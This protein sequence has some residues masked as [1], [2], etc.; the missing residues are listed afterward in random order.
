MKRIITMLASSLLLTATLSA[1]DIIHQVASLGSVSHFGFSHD[2]R[3]VGSCH[4]WYRD[5]LVWETATG[6]IV[7]R[8]PDVYPIMLSPEAVGLSHDGSFMAVLGRSRSPSGMQLFYGVN[9]EEEIKDAYVDILSKVGNLQQSPTYYL[10]IYDCDRNDIV[11]NLPTTGCFAWNTTNNSLVNESAP[12]R[13]S[14]IDF[15]AGTSRSVLGAERYAHDAFAFSP[16]G[17]VLA[18]SSRGQMTFWNAEDGRPLHRT[19]YKHRGKTKAIFFG[20]DYFLSGGDDETVKLWALPGFELLHSFDVENNDFAALA[21]SPDGSH[22]AAVDERPT[23]YVWRLPSRELVFSKG[24][25]DGLTSSGNLGCWF[26]PDSRTLLVRNH[27]RI[28]HFGVPGGESLE[29]VVSNGFDYH[30]PTGRAAHSGSD[31]FDRPDTAALG[32]YPGADRRT[33]FLSNNVPKTLYYWD[34]VMAEPL[35]V[36]PGRTGAVSMDG[37]LLATVEE[38]TVRFYRTDD[39]ALISA[40]RSDRLTATYRPCFSKDGRYLYASV[41]ENYLQKWEVASGKLVSEKRYGKRCGVPTLSPDGRKLLI[42]SPLTAVVDLQREELIDEV[43]GDHACF[44]VDGEYFFTGTDSG[45][46]IRFKTPELGEP[47]Q[48]ENINVPDS[49]GVQSL[50]VHPAGGQLIIGS[51]LTSGSFRIYDLERDAM[52]DE[53]D[54]A[55]GY[56]WELCHL[57][58]GGVL[59]TLESPGILL[60]RDSLTGETLASTIPHTQLGKHFLASPDGRLHYSPGTEGFAVVREGRSILS[61][62]DLPAS[63]DRNLPETIRRRA[64]ALESPGD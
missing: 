9:N 46:V 58:E 4:K 27:N 64:T 34:F 2:G 6:R 56:I 24:Y 20:T 19:G 17:T 53:I 62:E 5:V 1:G 47:V 28:L 45:R 3:F 52:V 38:G 14:I 49:H 41:P 61:P 21:I 63:F 7:N 57:G 32:F 59:L 51:N 55:Y 11:M 23:A 42:S 25:N 12:G 8:F 39:F 60:Y 30:T 37:G 15:D 22:L 16:D 13:V 40:G 26:S 33:G 36:F 43:L 18:G 10:R 35:H 50:S 54:G 48:W 44:S 31:L 29:T